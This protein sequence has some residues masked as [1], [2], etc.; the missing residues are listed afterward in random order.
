MAFDID[1]AGRKGRGSAGARAL[2]LNRDAA[3]EMARQVSL[4]GLGGNLVLDCVGPLNAAA[5]NEIHS[6]TLNALKA[7]GLVAP[8]VL[9]PSPIDLLQASIPWRVQPL[10]DQINSDPSETVL[11]ELLRA[12]QSEAA[13]NPM[14]F[15]ELCLGGAVWQAYLARRNDA[16]AAIEAHFGGR[17]TVSESPGAES[18]ITKR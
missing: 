13:A 5:R 10:G 3:R 9:K 2:A 11:L 16:D 18:R 1:T 15:Y 7:I 12:A 4:R 6:T 8:K 17:L 14:K